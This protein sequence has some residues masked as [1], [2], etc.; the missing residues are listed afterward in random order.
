MS[1]LK[2]LATYIAIDDAQLQQLSQAFAPINYIKGEFMF[3]PSEPPNHLVFL[4]SGLV[5]CYYLN[6]DKEVNLRLITDNSAVLPFTSYITQQP[7]DEYIQCMSN[8]LG[9]SVQLDALEAI[10]LPSSSLLEMRRVLAERH[11]LSMERRLRMLQLKSAEQRYHCFCNVMEPRI[12]QETPAYHIASYLGIT[13]ES[14]SRI[15]RSSN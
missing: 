9:Y 2:A 15:K 11:Y 1:L 14:L 6:D 13:P 4:S 12:V 10:G 7:S 5:R 3:R 8:C